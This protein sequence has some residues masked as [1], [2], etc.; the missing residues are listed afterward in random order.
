MIYYVYRITNIIEKKHYYGYRGTE[1]KPEDDLGKKY[2]SSSSDKQFKKLQRTNPELFKYKIL[3]LFTEKEHAVLME[4]KLHKKFDVKNHPSFYNLANQLHEGFCANNKGRP[5]RKDEDNPMVKKINIFDNVGNLR[6]TSTGSFQK[7][8]KKNNLPETTFRKSYYNGGIPIFIA[9]NMATWAK[10][11]GFG[12]FIGWYAL[13][14]NS[15]NHSSEK[16]GL[17]IESEKKKYADNVEKTKNTNTG[18][19]YNSKNMRIFDSDGIVRFENFPSLFKLCELHN[20]PQSAFNTSFVKGGIPIFK[21]KYGSSRAIKEGFGEFIGWYAKSGDPHTVDEYES[22]V[23]EI[24]E[25]DEKVQSKKSETMIGRSR[26]GKKI[27]IYDSNGNVVYET[28]GNFEEICI[29]YNLPKCLGA[30]HRNDGKPI[31]VSSAGKKVAERN[32]QERFIGWYAKKV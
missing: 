29:Q 10:K 18:K 7:F 32:N 22:M 21:T 16:L 6:F 19:A 3:K 20:L 24:I 11:N 13:Y 15:E 4:I 17:L 26:N 23:S 5:G 14:G 28:D 27:N 30:S 12:N 9:E 8:C 25:K 31:F 1:R 2:F